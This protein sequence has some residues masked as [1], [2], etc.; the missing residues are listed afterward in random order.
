MSARPQAALPARCRRVSLEALPDD[1]V[2]LVQAGPMMGASGRTARPA[3][4]ESADR[5]R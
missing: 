4:E 3:G 5:L 1:A 2:F